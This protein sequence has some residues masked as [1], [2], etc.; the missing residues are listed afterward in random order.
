MEKRL[1]KGH[2]GDRET[3][4]KGLPLLQAG[5]KGAT[6]LTGVQFFVTIDCRPSGSFG[7]SQA[8]TLERVA[9]SFSRGGLPDPGIKPV[10]LASPALGGGF[11]FLTTEPPGKPS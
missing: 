1:E 3:R 2:S 10:S 6:V 11:F 8:R 4:N 9:I 7:I 5:G